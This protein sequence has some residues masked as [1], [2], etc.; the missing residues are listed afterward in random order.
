MNVPVHKGN[1][2][3]IA[4]RI[5]HEFRFDLLRSI[6]VEQFSNSGNCNDAQ[7][8]S[9]RQLAAGCLGCRRGNEA[10]RFRAGLMLECVGTFCSRGRSG[11]RDS[12]E[13][14]TK[15]GQLGATLASFAANLF[16]HYALYYV[17]MLYYV[18]III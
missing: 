10:A 2:V 3:L 18:A 11:I 9:W 7:G 6:L 17:A 15:K 1:T 12:D 16:S 8:A 13:T 5:R 4:E 14:D